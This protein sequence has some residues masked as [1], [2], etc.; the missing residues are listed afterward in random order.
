MNIKNNRSF[1]KGTIL[2]LCLVILSLTLLNIAT[3]QNKIS[4]KDKTLSQIEKELYI[5]GLIKTIFGKTFIVED[6]DGEDPIFYKINNKLAKEIR[7][8]N[9]K[10][11]FLKAEGLKETKYSKE[12]SAI[13]IL[14]ISSKPEPNWKKAEVI[15]LNNLLIENG[16]ND[17]LI[18]IQNPDT[19]RSV[20]YAV[21]GKKKLLG[22]LQSNKEKY[23]D[24]KCLVIHKPSDNSASYN[25]VAIVDEVYK[26]KDKADNELSGITDS[27]GKDGNIDAELVGTKWEKANTEYIFGKTEAGKNNILSITEN[28]K[29]KSQVSYIVDDSYKNVLEGVSESF[30]VVEGRVITKN[31]YSKEI[32]VTELL[33]KTNNPEFDWEKTE[34]EVFTAKVESGQDNNLALIRDWTSRSRVTYYIH[35]EKYGDFTNKIGNYVKV[36]CLVFINEPNKLTWT[37]HC[38]VADIIKIDT[39]PFKD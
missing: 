11:V 21:Y 25:K 7:K 14:H 6:W 28:W 4:T 16:P 35:G 1:V 37:K 9:K 15:K 5:F 10:F 38:I 33:L 12:I 29:S 2:F 30:V 22:K 17:R 23:L 18:L 24:A 20:I 34:E 3:A 36:K 27:E 31:E 26:I 13:E 39:K 19:K 8:H 32:L